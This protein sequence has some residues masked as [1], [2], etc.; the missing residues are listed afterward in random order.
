MMQSLTS[1]QKRELAVLGELLF[2]QQVSAREAERALARFEQWLAALEPEARRAL[3]VVLTAMNLLPLASRHLRLLE[4]L[5]P[6]EAQRFLERVRDPYRAMVVRVVKGL[7]GMAYLMD[8]ALVRR[9]GYSPQPMRDGDLPATPMPPLQVVYPSGDGI[10]EADVVV[11]GSG[12][13]GATVAMR[14][15]EAGLRVIVLEEG[16]LATPADAQLPLYERIRRFYRASGFTFAAGVPPIYLPM[17]C[18]VG[19]TTVV[20]SG[21]CFRTPEFVL[22]QWQQQFGVPITLSE[23]EPLFERIERDLNIQPVPEAVLGGNAQ[24]MRRGAERLGIRHAPLMRPQAHCRGTGVCAMVCPYNAKLD[25]RLT[26]LPRAQRA[27]AR[28]Y[29]RCRALRILIEGTHAI[30]VEA[31]VLDAAKQPTGYLLQVRARAV[32]VAAGAIYT[33]VL[34][35]QSGVRHPHLGRHLHLHPSVGV[36]AEMDEPVEAWRGVMQSYGITEWLEEG[37]LLEATFPPLAVGYGVHPLPFW[38]ERHQHLLVRANALV[39][40][41]VL[42]AERASAGRLCRLPDGAILPLYRF[43]SRDAQRL[44]L[45]IARAAR[46]LF[47]AGAH[48][49]YTDLPGAECL[50]TEADVEA[51]LN[52]RWHA[53]YLNLSAYHPA[54]TCRM[55][56]SP[57]LCPVAPTGQLHRYE[58]L[59]VADASVLPTPTVVNPQV[60]IMMVAHH[61]AEQ[62]LKRWR[63][64]NG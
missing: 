27:G 29:G 22:R 37:I 19:G 4:Q 14:L 34:L 18:T 12:A 45:G 26:Y 46:V 56:V 59:W 36:F 44:L 24:V 11:I 5:P 47:A 31:Q 3:Q 38:G 10:D 32:V 50:H 20:N 9:L 60:T 28:L 62:I 55:G 23:A 7:C 21:T 58:N 16:E 49:V 41:G 33:P 6:H 51:M 43:H 48:T 42:V 63:F 2:G 39:G 15:A 13:G 64:A 53:G 1:A 8:E 35:R 57:D 30:G 40:V 61:V 17:G 52:R 54:G 25:M